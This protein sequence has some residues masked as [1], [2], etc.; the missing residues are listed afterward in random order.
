LP[1]SA[2]RKSRSGL[3]AL[4]MDKDGDT[5]VLTLEGELDLANADL[6]EVELEESLGDGAR[7]IVVDMR[8]LEF[9]DSTGIAL[10]VTALGEDRVDGI[11]PGG[12]EASGAG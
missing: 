3:L 4:A 7:R 9:I 11:D 5:R 1:S 6:L 10:L 12:L 8:K 2:H